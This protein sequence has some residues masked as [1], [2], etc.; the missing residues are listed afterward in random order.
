MREEPFVKYIQLLEHELKAC[1]DPEVLLNVLG[2]IFIGA[3]PDGHNLVSLPGPI[4]CP[5]GILHY[6]L[7]IDT[8][9]RCPVT[10]Q[11]VCIQECQPAMLEL[12]KSLRN[13]STHSIQEEIPK[14]PTY[15]E[16]DNTLDW[17]E[18]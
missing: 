17:E 11:N 13:E 3:K 8:H 16:A 10:G 4:L 7:R 6:R 1:K 9:D 15:K 14:K 5:W 2:S 18:K 12:M